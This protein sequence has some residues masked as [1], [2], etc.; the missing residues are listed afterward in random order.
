M[1]ID[2][3]SSNPNSLGLF[4]G[5]VSFTIKVIRLGILTIVDFAPSPAELV[6]KYGARRT[7]DDK[8]EVQ[9]VNLPW[10]VKKE[11]DIA[12]TPGRKYTVE[13]VRVEGLVPPWE[14]YVAF[15]D[16]AGEFGAGYIITRRRRLFN[17]VYKS[18]SKPINLQTAPYIVIRPVEL[19]L[20]DREN[21]VECVDRA[22][23][24]KYIAVFINAPASEIQ[25]IQVVLN[26]VVKENL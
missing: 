25:N 21:T 2:G 7:H 22:F 9:A 24:A 16:T 15:I 6:K 12:I 8:Y 19:Q 18:Y 20:T 23:R 5:F 3:N 1:P 4:G 13:G 26:P 11:L 14:A 17:C 10:V